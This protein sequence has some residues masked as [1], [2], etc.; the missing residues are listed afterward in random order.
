LGSRTWRDSSTRRNRSNQIIDAMG[1]VSL[2]STD[3][4]SAFSGAS[5]GV[6][7][8]ARCRVLDG[9]RIPVVH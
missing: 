3:V 9:G 4:R 2:V 6:R 8:I 5:C 1:F 7:Q